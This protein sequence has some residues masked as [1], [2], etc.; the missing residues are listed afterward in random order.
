MSGPALRSLNRA[1][2]TMA[3]TITEELRK[4]GAGSGIRVLIDVLVYELQSTGLGV[5]AAMVLISSAWTRLEEE[6]SRPRTIVTP[7]SADEL[8]EGGGE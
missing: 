6:R 7:P 8:G 5:Q 4:L 3:R 2:T 1:E